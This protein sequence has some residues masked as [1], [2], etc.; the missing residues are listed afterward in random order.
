MAQAQ[1]NY[2]SESFTNK[3]ARGRDGLTQWYIKKLVSCFV[4]KKSQ[5]DRKNQRPRF[6][7]DSVMPKIQKNQ[8]S[9]DTMPG[10]PASGRKN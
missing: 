7:S 10:K 1:E 8:T 9:T 2:Y 4:H 5:N 6:V 3:I